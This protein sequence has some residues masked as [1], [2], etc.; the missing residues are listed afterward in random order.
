[1]EWRAFTTHVLLEARP[2][3]LNKHGIEDTPR[4]DHATRLTYSARSEDWSFS[5]KA[6]YARLRTPP[7][8]SDGFPRVLLHRLL[9]L[10][11][12]KASPS[13]NDN[14]FKIR[15]QTSF[16]DFIVIRLRP[17]ARQCATRLSEDSYSHRPPPTLSSTRPAGLT[18]KNTK[19]GVA[20]HENPQAFH[21]PVFRTPTTHPTAFRVPRNG[22]S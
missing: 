7:Q 1:M 12:S 6:K 2:S 17:V 13:A 11:A 18:R 5:S 3:A 8:T 10:P 22:L 4:D 20:G 9:V 19:T 14:K 16:L 15:G 21:V